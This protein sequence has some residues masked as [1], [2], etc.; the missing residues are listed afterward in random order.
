[1]FT[2]EVLRE[3]KVKELKQLCDYYKIPYG[4]NIRKSDL[5]DLVLEEFWV[6]DNIEAIE[7][8]EKYSVRVRRIREQNDGRH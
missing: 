6:D 4:K 2:Y 8:P 5:I 1:M 3:S 7:P